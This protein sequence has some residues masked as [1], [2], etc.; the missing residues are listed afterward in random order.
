MRVGN[1]DE[2]PKSNGGASVDG[3]RK[4]EGGR[5][6]TGSEN[7]VEVEKVAQSKT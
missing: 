7:K 2:I 5:E 3:E 6:R 1:G 4:S